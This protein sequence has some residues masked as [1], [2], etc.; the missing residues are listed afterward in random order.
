MLLLCVLVTAA[1]VTATLSG[2]IGM[3]GGALLLA[4]ILSALS[5]AQSIPVH[6][7][8]Q[9]VSNG[10][11]VLAFLPEV[12][13]RTVT[14]FAVG[15]LPGGALGAL[16]LWRLGSATQSDPGLKALVGVYI[17]ATLALPAPSQQMRRGRWWDWPLLGLVAGSAALTVG[18]V[19]PLIA[20]LFAR[21][22]F[23]RRQ[24]VATKA[25]CQALLHAVKLPAFLALWTFDYTRF[26]AMILLMSAAVVPGTLAGRYLLTHHVSERQFKRLYS[27]ALAL[28]GLKLVLW[29]GLRIWMAA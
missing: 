23:T 24:L 13:W 15:V 17:L 16:F 11:R 6:G 12:R 26:A 18:A 22:E 28:A 29:D 1:F 10:T 9:L 20:P 14:S 3:G 5:H 27:W 2:I 4:V 19:G 8:V 7:A 21:R 25:L